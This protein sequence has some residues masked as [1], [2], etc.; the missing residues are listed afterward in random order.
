[1]VWGI[2]ISFFLGQK[3]NVTEFIIDHRN[4]ISFTKVGCDFYISMKRPS[5]VTTKWICYL[6][7][8]SLL[9]FGLFLISCPRRLTFSHLSFQIIQCESLKVF[10][11]SEGLDPGENISK[12]SRTSFPPIRNEYI[13]WSFCWEMCQNKHFLDLFSSKNCFFVLDTLSNAFPPFWNNDK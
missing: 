13:Y 1:M 2:T 12:G 6:S 3:Y 4:S 9:M 7:A 10:W 5:F 11:I 8:E